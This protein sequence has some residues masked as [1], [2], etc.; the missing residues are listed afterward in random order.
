M[1][2]W[3][4]VLVSPRA[5][6]K[7]TL[8]AIDAGAMQ[9]AAVIDESSRLL[10]VVSDGDVRRA[11]LRGKDL[12]SPVTDIMNVSPVTI[13]SGQTHQE[14]LRLMRK[15][16]L[17]H[18]LVVDGEKRLV[19]ILT[20]QE[21]LQLQT[22]SNPVVLMAGGLGSRLGALTANCPKPLLKVGG[23]PILEIILQSFLDCGFNNF[24]IAVNY[25]AQ[26]IEEYFGDGTRF[27]TSIRYL[28]EEKRLGTAGGLALLPERP[29]QPV[30]VMNGDILTRCNH[31]LLLEAHVAS[32]AAATM[33]VRRHDQQIPY[34]V[35]HYTAD[36]RLTGVE[37]K[38][39]LSV[40]ISA[41]INIVSPEALSYIPKGCFFDIPDLFRALL[42]DNKPVSVYT[43]SDYWLDIGHEEDYRRA[44][45]DFFTF[46]C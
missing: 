39:I 15:N 44:D 31:R 36:G 4:H 11:L 24:F 5:S 33:V 6:I 27:D 12:S 10:G 9:L 23:K 28:R 18:I 2:K 38:P 7:E 35:V 16:H 26:M 37:E 30:L 14:A 21:L 17:R 13:G 25:R 19:D 29:D 8:Q 45:D 3:Q 32:G 40:S 42:A 22:L 34:G 41:G 46:F 20:M 43:T 1:V